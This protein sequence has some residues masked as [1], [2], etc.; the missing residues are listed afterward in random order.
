MIALARAHAENMARREKLDH[1]G[2]HERR[3]P[4]G[5]RAEKR[6]VWLRRKLMHDRLLTRE[7]GGVTTSTCS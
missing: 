5:A 3:G 6:R 7:Q 2:F 1:A 4:S